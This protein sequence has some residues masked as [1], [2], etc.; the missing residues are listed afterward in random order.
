VIARA[1]LTLLLAAAPPEAVPAIPGYHRVSEQ[2]ATAGQPDEAALGQLKALGFRTVVN[3]RRPSEDPIV[4]K[5]KAIVEAAGLRYVSVPLT[6]ATFSSSDAEQVRAAL[7]SGPVLLHCHT[8]NRAGGVWAVL[9]ARDGMPWEQAVEEG[10]KAGLA[11]PEM[12]EA[13][14]KVA[15]EETPR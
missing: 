9:A 7:A 3:L 5:E 1:L 13:A 6:P 10:R 11:S 12:T 8:G 4:E 2:V 15:A 14:R